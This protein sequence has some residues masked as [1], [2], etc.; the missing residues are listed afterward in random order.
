MIRYRSEV[1]R[2]TRDDIERLV[3]Y[4]AQTQI[5]GNPLFVGKFNEQ[6]IRW[7]P[8]ESVEVIST[9]EQGTFED[10]PRLKHDKK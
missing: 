3:R 5:A 10:L 4:M 9:Y 8:D 6:I 1:V 2:F 7:L